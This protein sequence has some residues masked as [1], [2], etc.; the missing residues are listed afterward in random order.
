L[1]G[2]YLPG[3]IKKLQ[4]KFA[5]Q[6]RRKSH[7]SSEHE[8]DLNQSVHG[9]NESFDNEDYYQSK[10]SDSSH[11]ASA[12]QSPYNNP[13]LIGY[14][15]IMPISPNY[16]TVH[17]IQPLDTPIA[18]NG[19]YTPTVMTSSGYITP[20]T[21]GFSTP[22]NYNTAY[23]GVPYYPQPY[24]S[25]QPSTLVTVFIDELCNQQEVNAIS[26]LC[27]Q[28][29]HVISI[30]TDYNSNPNQKKFFKQ[31]FFRCKVLVNSSNDAIYLINNLHYFA[32][33]YP[34]I[35]NTKIYYA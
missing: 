27:N 9:N 5:D 33:N 18:Y 23:T 10:S 29:V 30:S 34:F 21:S 16:T 6:N 28:I 11:T 7:S 15:N 2:K 25:M 4:V 32:T 1:H 26:A 24:F 8:S 22:V 14:P 19:S 31:L 35:R 20:Y 13:H 17:P 12:S 3:C